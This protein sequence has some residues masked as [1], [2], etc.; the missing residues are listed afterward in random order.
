MSF[1]EVAAK[2]AR[3]E[4]LTALHRVARRSLDRFCGDVDELREIAD[5]CFLVSQFSSYR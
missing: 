5:G 4:G 2:F 3:C 1:D